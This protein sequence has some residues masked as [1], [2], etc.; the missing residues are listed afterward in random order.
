[1]TA[2]AL[3]GALAEHPALDQWVAFATPGRITIYTG[4]VEIG[5]D[6]HRHYVRRH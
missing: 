4:K 1:M 2:A 5:Q 3:T 6:T